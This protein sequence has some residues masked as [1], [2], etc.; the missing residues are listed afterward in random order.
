MKKNYIKP[1]MSI[2]ELPQRTSLLAGSDYQ[3][4]NDPADTI[5]DE[6]EVF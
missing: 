4:Y 1:E 6:G 2:V 3:L 5:D